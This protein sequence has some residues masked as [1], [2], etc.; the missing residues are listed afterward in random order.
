MSIRTAL[1]QKLMEISEYS[2]EM[3][4]YNMFRY[5]I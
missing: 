4:R 2:E 1:F 5:G 3:K